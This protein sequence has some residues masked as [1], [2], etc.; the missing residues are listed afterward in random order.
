M[1]EEPAPITLAAEV[2]DGAEQTVTRAKQGLDTILGHVKDDPAKKLQVAEEIVHTTA[3]TIETGLHTL[4]QAVFRF[5]SNVI[6]N[7]NSGFQKIHEGVQSV[8]NGA[9]QGVNDGFGALSGGIN[10]VA[11]G[12]NKNLSSVGQGVG[13]IPAPPPPPT[14]PSP[15]KMPSP[16][17]VGS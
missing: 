15:P 1:A 17:K 3:D 10:E 12:I 6:A 11:G 8:V 13:N 7:V 4:G 14:P 16:P 5:P 2:V 9:L